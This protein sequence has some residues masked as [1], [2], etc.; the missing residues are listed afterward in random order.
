M[1]AVT[2]NYRNVRE[3]LKRWVLAN[4]L[5]ADT[6]AAWFED[7]TVWIDPPKFEELTRFPALV[8]LNASTQFSSPSE[9]G[10]TIVARHVLALDF[11]TREDDSAA[12]GQKLDALLTAF[13]T[14]WGNDAL[15]FDAGLGNWTYRTQV[16]Y[17]TEFY[18][19]LSDQFGA[20]SHFA[21]KTIRID[22][23]LPARTF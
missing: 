18:A 22:E 2:V 15:R 19:A 23:R 11:H 5:N 14:A 21:S 20:V 8:I 17:P 7:H 13:D 10:G 3:A 1:A 12:A 4:V 16:G 6:G 9:T